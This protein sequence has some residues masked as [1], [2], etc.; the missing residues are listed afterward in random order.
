MVAYQAGCCCGRIDCC[1]CHPQP[2]QI[3]V[4]VGAGGWLEAQC[5]DPCCSLVA[6]E[7]TLDLNADGSQDGKCAWAFCQ[8]NIGERKDRDE[9]PG[10]QPCG[11]FW[12][13]TVTVTRDSPPQSFDCT[14][15]CAIAISWEDSPEG[16]PSSVVCFPNSRA[17]IPGFDDDGEPI[18]P[19]PSDGFSVSSWTKTFNPEIGE[20]AEPDQGFHIMTPVRFPNSFHG[21]ASLINP[22][23]GNLIG[24]VR[25]KFLF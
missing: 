12:F 20:C 25:M 17:F 8:D 24:P 15:R 4:D 6:G 5:I 9:G 13:L 22:C 21:G 11:D 7:Y 19:D 14:Y 10:D 18:C 1:V 16:G 2:D 3:L 23:T